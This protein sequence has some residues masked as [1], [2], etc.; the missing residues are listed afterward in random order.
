MTCFTFLNHEGLSRYFF[1]HLETEI[2]PGNPC[3]LERE[4]SQCCSL[5]SVGRLVLLLLTARCILGGFAC[6]S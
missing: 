5:L 2:G 4:G 3:G 1:V 6:V